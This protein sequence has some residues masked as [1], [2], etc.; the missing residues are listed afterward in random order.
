MVQ[1]IAWSK[2]VAN[3]SSVSISQVTG[4]LWVGCVCEQILIYFDYTILR[5]SFTAQTKKIGKIF[6]CIAS[7]T[8]SGDLI[9]LLWT[10]LWKQSTPLRS[11]K[12]TLL[13]KRLSRISVKDYEGR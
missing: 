11:F 6:P 10:Q 12:W 7:T 4:N 13:G 9:V 3:S 2:H 1:Q 8:L 5:E